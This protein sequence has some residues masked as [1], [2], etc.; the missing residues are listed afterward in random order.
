MSGKTH[1]TLSVMQEFD[2]HSTVLLM[3]MYKMKNHTCMTKLF[4]NDLHLTIFSL[5]SVRQCCGHCIVN[6]LASAASNE[7]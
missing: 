5:V 7:L 6:K 1:N 4:S 2:G 3:C